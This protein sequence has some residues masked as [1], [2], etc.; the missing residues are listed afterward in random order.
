[1]CIQPCYVSL[2][3]IESIQYLVAIVDKD[4]K[5]FQRD[6]KHKCE[7][8]L[9]EIILSWFNHALFFQLWTHMT[10]RCMDSQ[11]EFQSEVVYV[12][13]TC[14]MTVFFLPLAELGSSRDWERPK[15]RSWPCSLPGCKCT[16][17]SPTGYCECMG[18]VDM[19]SKGTDPVSFWFYDRRAWLVRV[20]IYSF[21]TIHA[22]TI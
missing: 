8:F 10:R 14:K 17:A 22:W 19:C 18:R 21:Q 7:N 15:R 2:P 11:S 1:M 6:R 5:A 16:G 9:T 20:I 13:V 12:R 3:S 4:F